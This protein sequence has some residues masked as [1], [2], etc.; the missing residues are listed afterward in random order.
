MRRLEV[1]KRRSAQ[2]RQAN[3]WLKILDIDLVIIMVV[4]VEMMMMMMM[5]MMMDLLQSTIRLRVLPMRPRTPTT[6]ERTPKIQ[7]LVI[8]MML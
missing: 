7:N 8:T 4:V 2:Q 6:D 1:R 3:R 5:M